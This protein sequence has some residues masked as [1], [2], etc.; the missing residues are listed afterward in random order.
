MTGF[1]PCCEAWVLPTGGGHDGPLRIERSSESGWPLF[2]RKRA[3]TAPS[4]VFQIRAGIRRGNEGKLWMVDGGP[5]RRWLSFSPKAER[6]IAYNLP[7]TRSGRLVAGRAIPGQ[8]ARDLLLYRLRLLGHRAGQRPQVVPR[9]VKLI[10]QGENN[11][12]A[13]VVEAHA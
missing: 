13:R 5:N 9:L 7:A 10:D 6:F 12:Q 8:P 1:L 11:R 3:N 2:L 4:D